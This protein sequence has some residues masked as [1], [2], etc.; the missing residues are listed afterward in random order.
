MPITLRGVL[1]LCLWALALPAIRR[2][3]MLAQAGALRRIGHDGRQAW[4]VVCGRGAAIP[5]RPS[6][7]CMVLGKALWLQFDSPTGTHRACLVD[8]ALAVRLR[9]ARRG[10]PNC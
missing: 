8:R 10:A 3:L 5:A 6:P 7:H 4:R 9:W 2:D 1:V